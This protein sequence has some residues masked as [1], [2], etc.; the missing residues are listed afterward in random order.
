MITNHP[1]CT[2]LQDGDVLMEVNGNNVHNYSQNEV[3]TLLEQ[4][5]KGSEATFAILRQSNKVTILS[6]I[7][8]LHVQRHGD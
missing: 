1:S 8:Y 2:Q 7:S 3:I 6:I 5:P 4:C